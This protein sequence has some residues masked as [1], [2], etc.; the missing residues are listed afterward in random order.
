MV[1]RIVVLVWVKSLSHLSLHLASAHAKR[2]SQHDGEEA[3]RHTTPIQPVT[4]DHWFLSITKIKYWWKCSHL[5][6]VPWHLSA[7][8]FLV[9]PKYDHK[10][11]WLECLKT[12]IQIRR[13]S[14]HL[15]DHIQNN[16]EVS[17][18]FKAKTKTTEQA[19]WEDNY[20]SSKHTYRCSILT[21]RTWFTWLTLLRKVNFDLIPVPADESDGLKTATVFC[22]YKP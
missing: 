19:R 8:V 1:R 2:V 7:P 11:S 18:L 22:T 16:G 14:S 5:L 9:D 10:K 3:S 6:A 20:I 15:S 4:I 13:R 12:H 17:D 21:V